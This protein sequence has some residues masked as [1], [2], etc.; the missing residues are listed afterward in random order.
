MVLQRIYRFGQR[1]VG[2]MGVFTG[3]RLVSSHKSKKEFIRSK[4]L[5]SKG[6]VSAPHA[7]SW[8]GDIAPCF[9]INGNN[10]QII[11]EPKHFHEVLKSN[12]R[13]ATQRIVFTSLYLGTGQLEQELV[14][15]IRE[16]CHTAKTKGNNNLE[17]H[18][19]L[20]YNRGSRGVEKSSRTMLTPLLKEYKDIISVHLYHTP[21]LRG[22]WKRL[23]TGRM[24][25]VIGLNHMKIYLFDDSFV[26]SGA[27][28]SND[29][30]TNRQDRYV[31]FNNC[32]ELSNFFTDLVKTV[33]SFSFQLKED[34][35][36][37]LHSQCNIHPFEGSDYEFKMEAKKRILNLLKKRTDNESVQ[38]PEILNQDSLG[39]S[40]SFD[41][42]NVTINIDDHVTESDSNSDQNKID[43]WIYPLIQ[44]GPF[45]IVDDEVAMKSIFRT[46]EKGEEIFLASG[47]F[48]L[49]DHYLQVILQQSQSKY[50]ILM[51]SP[52]VNGFFGAKGFVGAV[53]AAYIYI[54]KRFYRLTGKY[55]QHDRIKLR[56]YFRNKWTFHVKGLWY[57]LKKDSQP[58]M[59]I[60]GSAN[61]GY[62]SV[63]RDLECQCAIVT[64]NNQLQ[65][66]LKEE[67]IRLYQSSTLVSRETFLQND[68]HVPLWIRIVTPL[69]RHFF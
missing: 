49:T 28:L 25:E 34:N 1:F 8:L 23:L 54:A 36:V 67:H 58:S 61:F 68:R 69:I 30:F 17:V 5:S 59:S 37:E 40:K 65:Q 7:F 42:S 44:M 11:D 2:F 66:Q 48:N 4:D 41:Q 31:L 29:Y 18:I 12:A 6:S 55:E 50:D 22:I 21:D 24:S 19:L 9:G 32:S 15:A 57:Y 26:I 16:A 13:K 43:T 39:N 3:V 53:P 60:V 27:N 63:Y 33:G 47:Y 38:I 52:E 62:R 45:G 20:D 46:A 64:N 51:A 56:E 14:D 35:S 10:V